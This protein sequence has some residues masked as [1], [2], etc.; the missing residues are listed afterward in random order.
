MKIT[1]VL[2]KLEEAVNTA[3]QITTNK[4]SLDVLACVLLSVED[5]ELVLRATNLDIG[6]KI[7][8]PV[9]VQKAG[10]V[11]VPADVFSQMLS[12]IPKSSSVR[13]VFSDNVLTIESD[14]TDTRIKTN[15]TDDFPNIPAVD[16]GTE[17]ELGA[18]ELTSGLKSVM[19]AA[20]PSSMKPALSSVYLNTEEEMLKFVSTDSFR[21]A[22]KSINTDVSDD[23]S[24]LIPK[25]NVSEI[26]RIF[27][28]LADDV[29][30]TIGDNQ[31]VIE[32]DSAYVSSRLVDGSF[33]DYK[34]IIPDSHSVDMTLPKQDLSDTLRLANI[35]SDKFNKLTIH[36]QPS[37]STVSFT[38]QNQ[39]IGKNESDLPADISG[40][41]EITTNFNHR[42]ITD[43]FSAIDS[44]EVMLS[45]SPDKPMVMRP[46]GDDSFLYLV[47]PM[48]D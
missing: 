28:D 12:N 46:V 42:Y 32:S 2:Q 5:G 26:V 35:F 7:T 33:P 15:P 24:I 47:M 37:D 3:E 45:M 40:D 10:T 4:A 8:I 34:K 44:Q 18:E 1:C 27:R 38:T 29:T 13:L 43:A 16:S 6:I 21:L 9:K 41:S 39:D 36:T 20:S 25:D 17:I 48:S 14:T 30:L 19:Y 31:L 23:L 22:E 11:A